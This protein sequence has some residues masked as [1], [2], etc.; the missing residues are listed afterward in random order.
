[1]HP[2]FAKKPT[3]S[4]QHASLPA[5]HPSHQ[6]TG[7]PT[8]SFHPVVRAK[9]RISAYKANL[10]HDG[11]R[12]EEH[13]M[14][15]QDTTSPLTLQRKLEVGASDDPLEEEADQIAES[16][17][18]NAPG[19]LPSITATNGVAKLHR[20]PP[21]PGIERA[22]QSERLEAEYHELLEKAAQYGLP[23]EILRVVEQN[24]T[25]AGIGVNEVS[26]NPIFNL[27][28]LH[29][30]SMAASQQLDPAAKRPSMAEIPT[31][32]FHE[33]THAWFDLMSSDPEVARFVA[34]QVK[35]YTGAPVESGGETSDPHLLFME[36]AAIYVENRVQSWWSTLRKLS[37][38]TKEG[39]IDD[40]FVADRRRDY[41]TAMARNVF[42][43]S[44]VWQLALPPREQTETTQ[45]I[46]PEFKRFMDERLLE[47]KIPDHFDDV[48]LF[49]EIVANAAP[50]PAVEAPAEPLQREVARSESQPWI[51]PAQVESVLAAPGVPMGKAA[52]RELEQRFGHSFAAVR[53]HADS[54]ADAAARAVNARAFTAGSHVVFT[55]GQ[56]A[57]ET[58][59]GR[60]LLAHEL[61]HVLQQRE[62]GGKE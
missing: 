41:D 55:R 44:H 61:A 10:E 27:L 35:Y 25:M 62:C 13:A 40:A 31:N 48:A 57:P 46:S 33:S 43:Y 21:P 30:P 22:Q 14:R 34:E 15:R 47:G 16:V 23:V 1:M 8:N 4:H 54:A 42:G 2:T 19:P 3:P 20:I 11:N 59:S 38:A 6:A 7:S 51:A 17:V 5:T 49:S 26:Y 24:V 36:A 29:E 45:S 28:L 50:K 18:Q 52:R 39:L 56:Y 32:V 53:V 58:S 37:I 12:V 9:L 60:R